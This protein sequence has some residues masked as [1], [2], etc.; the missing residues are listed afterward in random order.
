VLTVTELL[1]REKVVGTFVEYFGEGA[2]TLS[3]TDRATLANMAPEYGATMGFFP[4]DEKTV[5]YMR[6]T[7]RSEADCVLFEAYFRAQGLFGI[8]RAGQIDYS[9]SVRLDLCSIVP[10]LA[11]PKRPQ[12]RIA[13]PDMASVQCPVQRTGSRKTALPGRRRAD[14]ALPDRGPGSLSATATC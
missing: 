1:R 13:L 2:S 6:T 12:D 3:V 7:G 14:A 9:R 8:P 11:G 5:N 10:S 4:V